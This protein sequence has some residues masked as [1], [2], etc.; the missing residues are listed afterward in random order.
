M[1][2]HV[3]PTTITKFEREASCFQIKP[4]LII[5]L[6][7]IDKCVLQIIARHRIHCCNGCCKHETWPPST[8]R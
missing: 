6:D 2:P 5:S 7:I 8:S 3:T 1:H 4:F